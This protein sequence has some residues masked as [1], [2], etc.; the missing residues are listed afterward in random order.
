MVKSYKNNLWIILLW[1]I[2][3]CIT[4]SLYIY[5]QYKRF[6][7]DEFEHIHTAWK[8]LQGQEIYIDFFQHHH[9]FFNYMLVPV[10][11]FFGSNINSLIASR[12]I[13]LF[14]SLCILVI[15]Y[16]LSIR[17]FKKTEIGIIGII[18]T[19][20]IVSFYSTSVEIR[21]D[22]LMTLTGMI[23]IYFLFVYYDNN[24]LKA[25]FVSSIFLAISFLILQKSMVFIVSIGI[26]LL[27]DLYKKRTSFKLILLYGVVFILCISPYYIYLFINGSL[28]QYFTMN[29]LVNYFI[30]QHTAKT[31]YLQSSMIE[32]IGTTVL[33]AIG[34]FTLKKS[35]V[36]R[37]LVIISISIVL[38]PLILFTNIWP[39][40]L[41]SAM[42]LIGIIASFA[43]YSTVKSKWIKLVIII[44]AISTPSRAVLNNI[45]FIQG[46]TRQSEQIEKIN[47]VLSITD[48]N[49]KIFDGGISFNL[50]RNDVH[51]FWFC[52]CCLHAYQKIKD[53]EFD[54]HEVIFT[55]KPK[56]V[57]IVELMNINDRRI[58]DYYRV[59][60]KY[61]DIL[62]R[63]E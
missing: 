5:A 43:L 33:Y 24:S 16:L 2:F 25:F 39:H 60:D 31:R 29:W 3:A 53:Y 10:I 28:E 57:G 18:L 62:I 6:L 4:V 42:P 35:G 13:M 27:Y 30:M 47:Y 52:G 56:V 7:N 36:Q 23:S 46:P 34:L 48:E 37:R 12:Y 45:L 40:Y 26:L 19:S 9:P 32:N 22:V 17:I 21:P 51:Y 54:M 11:D 59:S 61:P 49:D 63:N 50:F 44:L 55:Q 14:I 15:T 38:L 58:K 41:I 20:T 1:V 8:I